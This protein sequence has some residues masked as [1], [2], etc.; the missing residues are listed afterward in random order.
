MK[1]KL[2]RL[3]S[4]LLALCMVV[5]AFTVTFASTAVHAGAEET[6]GEE[7]YKG[8]TISPSFDITTLDDILYASPEDKLNSMSKVTP[9]LDKDGNA[10]LDEYGQAT[11][12]YSPWIS[13]GEYELYVQEKSGEVAV[14]NKTTGQVLFSNP[15]NVRSYVTSSS[16]YGPMYSQLKLSYEIIKKGNKSETMDSYT[17]AA[18]HENQIKVSY[19]RNGV[20]V[21]YTIGRA[22]QRRLVPMAMEKYRWETVL[23]DKIED[24]PVQK[25]FRAFYT[26]IDLNHE[27][28]PSVEVTRYE[29]EYPVLKKYHENSP[30]VSEDYDPAKEAEYAAKRYP[31][32]AP[33]DPSTI[34]GTHDK[35]KY[36]Y[37]VPYQGKMS[38]YV[39]GN[40]TDQ[41]KNRIEEYIRSWAPEYNYDT[42]AY[43]HEL[44]Q[45]TSIA[46]AIPLFKMALEYRLDEEGFN[47]RLPAS[48]ITFD[49][50]N[51]RLTSVDILPYMGAGNNNNNGYV[52]VPD[53][54][55]TL[56]R[57]EDAKTRENGG[58]LNNGM[59]YGPDNAYHSLG[60]YTGKNEKMRY[61][62]YGIIENDT[63]VYEQNEN[64]ALTEQCPHRFVTKTITADCKTQQ[65]GGVYEFCAICGKLNSVTDVVPYEHTGTVKVVREANC[66]QEGIYTV[67]C[68]VCKQTH[69]I[70]EPKTEHTYEE[71]IVADKENH[72]CYAIEKCITKYTVEVDGE[73][74]EMECGH[75]NEEFEKVETDHTYMDEWTEVHA[76]G[77][78]YRSNTC[79]ECGYYAEEELE[80]TF[81]GE[82]ETVHDRTEGSCYIKHVCTACGA[83]VKE[84]LEH[85]YGDPTY[86][87]NDEGL[88][89]ATEI[90]K[91]CGHNE[92]TLSRHSAAD[93]GTKKHDKTNHRCYI[94]FTCEHCN[95]TYSEAADHNMADGKCADCGYSEEYTETHVHDAAGQCYRVLV[96][97]DGKEIS[98][99]A[100]DHEFGS[101][102]YVSATCT[103]WGFTAFTCVN[104][105][106]SA[107]KIYSKDDPETAPTGHDYQWDSENKTDCLEGYVSN[108]KCVNCGDIRDSKEVEA[109]GHLYDEGECIV[110]ETK[111]NEG[112][113]KFVCQFEGCGHIHMEVREPLT[114]TDEPTEGEDGDEPTEGE[115]GEEPTEGED[116][117]EPSEDEEGTTK[118]PVLVEIPR[119][120]GFVAIM[121]AGS[122]LAT[123]KAEYNTSHPYI[124]TYMTV[125]PRPQDTYNLADAISSGADAEWTVVSERKYSGS[126][127]MKY[128]MLQDVDYSAVDS[129]TEIDVVYKDST[130]DATYAGMAAAYRAYLISTGALKPLDVN[131]SGIPLYLEAFGATSIS[132]SF[133]TFPTVETV[134]LTTFED[135]KAIVDELN[136]I[137]KED[138]TVEYKISNIQF[139]LNGFTNGGMISTMPYKV[140][141]EK[142]VGGNAGFKDFV[143]FAKDHKIGVYP[144]FDFAYVEDTDWFDGYS[145]SKHAV[146][147]IDGRYIMKRDY[148][149]TFQIFTGTGLTAIS[150]SVYDYFFDAFSANYSKFE[151]QG[152]SVGSLGT[153]LNSDFDEDE[154]YNREDSR[155]FTER[156]LA[157]LK[158]EY[159]SVMIDGGNAYAIPY[160]DHIL[161][162][163]LTGSQQLITSES[164]PFM[165][166]VLHGSVNYAGSATNMSSSLELE[167]L[168]IIE[169]G[170]SPYFIIATQNT[171]YLKENNALSKYYS[172]DYSTWKADMIA[173][174]RKLNDN[175]KDVQG[176]QF[177]SHGH[178][179]GYRVPDADENYS[180]FEEASAIIIAAIE[181]Y[182]A[183]QERYAHAVALVER[184]TVTEVVNRLR[185]EAGNGIIDMIEGGI[186][187]EEMAAIEGLKAEIDEYLAFGNRDSIKNNVG[188]AKKELDEETAKYEAA[189]TQYGYLFNVKANED[190]SYNA[191]DFRVLENF[192]GAVYK[193]DDV[194]VIA[195]EGL[196]DAEGNPVKSPYEVDDKTIVKVGYDN[197][198]EFYLNYNYFDVIV[199]VNGEQHVIGSYDFIKVENN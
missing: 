29:N 175:L 178:V 96:D 184:M 68:T 198:V 192:R 40:A 28:I 142:V 2:N 92:I 91:N 65:N 168:D 21:E 173:T 127:A 174:Y 36:N 13:S 196:V 126:Y 156:L 119:G 150:A 17:D 136:A 95:A 9:L 82:G 71:F 131:E 26:L 70:T 32:Y 163:S 181:K 176:A 170:A 145:D 63:I 1:L 128:I 46:A 143:A 54:S 129:K 77:R 55:G 148:D 135:L 33:L 5:G 76:D 93:N 79:S 53:G 60:N 161:N 41:E 86:K 190:G 87:E 62:V 144:D 138:G 94:E 107:G 11:F 25:K 154:P 97:K 3:M 193:Q 6:E 42:L 80:H 37:G 157:N 179:S 177:I 61:P 116:G 58:T 73:T 7:V 8:A 64:G 102:S 101:R 166:M 35:A 112:V 153:D 133:L 123:L 109:D 186:T 47:V 155:E 59:L 45:Y 57:F 199:T 134:P 139:R 83:V 39:L 30:Y 158:K 195:N 89:E 117:E 125:T 78:C 72:I 141:F 160:A 67:D 108:D 132:S 90:C 171:R 49:E 151:N 197:G 75:I 74:V 159:T 149:P 172:V 191:D 81:E 24:E 162:M 113:Y 14:K 167:I 34:E 98:K 189:M 48:S 164:V 104:C 84:E 50:D 105:E 43:D 19:I 10:L 88:C 22:D 66:C 137:K 38:L 52:F 124:Y 99:V 121:T 152:I 182:N 146:K 111:Y 56:I 103:E 183:A 180:Q 122:A 194:Y 147:T 185:N 20:C 12:E 16:L 100:V 4:A 130:H 85:E 165:S 27:Y 15:Y 118:E 110:A 18:L 23:Y 187:E 106:Y 140:E 69:T 188:E 120:H 44:V 169:N 51:F 114:D 31:Y 115:D